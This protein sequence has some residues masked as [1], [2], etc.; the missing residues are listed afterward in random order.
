MGERESKNAYGQESVFTIHY[1]T[2]YPA[3]LCIVM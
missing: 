1:W 3:M 2:Y